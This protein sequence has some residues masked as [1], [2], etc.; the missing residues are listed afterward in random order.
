[1]MFCSLCVPSSFVVSVAYEL[2]KRARTKITTVILPQYLSR[3]GMHTRVVQ[4]EIRLH[5]TAQMG[6]CSVLHSWKAAVYEDGTSCLIDTAE[7]H[8][9]CASV[10][11]WLRKAGNSW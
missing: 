4:A 6:R 1:M 9:T 8:W 5:R 3:S 11:E 2:S 7:S 10:E